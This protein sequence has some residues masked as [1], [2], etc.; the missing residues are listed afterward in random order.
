MFH[1]CV[2]NMLN[3]HVRWPLREQWGSWHSKF[4]ASLALIIQMEA[5][6][7]GVVVTMVPRGRADLDLLNAF[8][9]VLVGNGKVVMFWIS[10]W[11]N[12]TSVVVMPILFYFL[13]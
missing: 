9:E 2:K 6:G 7:K 11:I 5:Q 3:T 8:T 13:C 4:T 1:I 10:S 12:N